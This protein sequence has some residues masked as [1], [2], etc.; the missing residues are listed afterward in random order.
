MDPKTYCA[1][2]IAELRAQA[3]GR[4]DRFPGQ[5]RVQMIVVLAHF[6]ALDLAPAAFAAEL[7]RLAQE[8]G[9]LGRPS[10]AAA[11]AAV[12]RDW[13]YHTSDLPDGEFAGSVPGARVPPSARQI[14][15]LGLYAAGLGT[16]EVAARL[17]ID[18]D[19]VRE[20]LWAAM[21]ALGA[22]SP[23]HALILALRAGLI[24]PPE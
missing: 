21:R 22:A 2:A 17:R 19:D 13:E 14:E 9:R 7:H 8:S 16:A 10:L 11:A 24:E 12:L 4:G 15:V 6:V 3:E 20:C 18:P 23:I 1:E 5:S